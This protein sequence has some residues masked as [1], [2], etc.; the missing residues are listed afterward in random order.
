MDI[1]KCNLDWFIE[2]KQLTS[3]KDRVWFLHKHF[4]SNIVVCDNNDTDGLKIR[5]TYSRISDKDLLL[6]NIVQDS[7]INRDHQMS[8]EVNLLCSC[9]SVDKCNG[10]Q[11]LVR[12]Y[13]MMIERLAPKLMEVLRI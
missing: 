11:N 9:I 7:L 4:W 1:K 6:L 8:Y 10:A 2:Y 13:N 3:L 5:I 12:N